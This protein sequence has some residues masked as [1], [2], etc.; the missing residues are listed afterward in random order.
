MPN[1]KKEEEL[2]RKLKQARGQKIENEEAEEKLAITKKDH[3]EKN[4]MLLLVIVAA[5]VI[6][7]I[8]G[9]GMWLSMRSN[10]DGGFS[11]QF[12]G[13]TQSV[14]E[15]WGQFK[16]ELPNS[17]AAEEEDQRQIISNPDNLSEEEI[18]ELEQKAFPDNK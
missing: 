8:G 3:P 2:S 5:V 13:I 15:S 6:A 1:N 10:D 11:Q 12:R 7:G 18:E 9:I 4:K 17:T 14:R 16:A